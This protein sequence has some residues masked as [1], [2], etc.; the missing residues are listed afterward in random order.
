MQMLQPLPDKD[1]RR[2]LGELVKRA[3]A[4]RGLAH[5]DVAERCGVDVET[6]RAWEEGERVPRG[7]QWARLKGSLWA[8]QSAALVWRAAIEVEENEAWSSLPASVPGGPHD[9]V[10][11]AREIE[12]E[13]REEAIMA[14]VGPAAQAAEPPPP[15]QEASKQTSFGEALRVARVNAGFTQMEMGELLGVGGGALSNWENEQT[16]PVLENW[17]KLVDLVPELRNCV[18]PGVQHR[19]KPVGNRMFPRAPTVDSTAPRVVHD[20]DSAP[21]AVPVPVPTP[22]PPAG[23][24][25]DLAPLALKYAQAVRALRRADAEVARLQRELTEAGVR[26]ERA[27]REQHEAQELLMMAVDEG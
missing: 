15:L 8:L 22:M 6:F 24:D 11:V 4:A 1:A 23:T 19:P 14:P 26:R 20:R 17:L 12:E 13:A 25:A 21:V 18:P 2:Q 16:T 9:A 7:R 5:R 27:S 10:T 3:R